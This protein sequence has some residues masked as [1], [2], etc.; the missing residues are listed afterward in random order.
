[1]HNNIYMTTIDGGISLKKRSSVEIS[2]TKTKKMYEKYNM[3]KDFDSSKNNKNIFFALSKNSS[4]SQLEKNIKQTII[5]MK[6]EIENKKKIF[7]ERKKNLANKFISTE[8]I[9]N[10]LKANNKLQPH[11]RLPLPNIDNSIIK[12]NNSFEYNEKSQKKIIKRLKTEIN[13]KAQNE[14]LFKRY[15]EV[16]ESGDDDSDEKSKVIN[17]RDISFSSNSN[18]I[19][20]L[21]FDLLIINANLYS[22]IIIPLSIAKDKNILKKGSNIEELFKY[23]NDIIYLFDFLIGLVRGYYNYEMEIVRNNKKIL[24]HYLKKDFFTDFIEAIPF[25]CI[26]KLLYRKDEVFFS[27]YSETK[28]FLIKLFFIFNKL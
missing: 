23:L 6:N 25:Y 28:T 3:Q 2:R 10:N 24:I 12:K 9:I 5:I 18:F 1:M 15:S 26:L 20:F 17:S 21:F 8:N 13:F 11:I 27:Y 4:N 14:E 16:I 19:L 7:Q 22:L